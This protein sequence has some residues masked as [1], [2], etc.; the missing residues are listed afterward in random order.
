MGKCSVVRQFQ[1]DVVQQVEQDN[2][3][4]SQGN[5]DMCQK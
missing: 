5:G 1:V 4:V 3:S 2:R